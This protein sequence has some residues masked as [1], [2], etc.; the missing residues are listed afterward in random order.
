MSKIFETGYRPLENILPPYGMWTRAKAE[1]PKKILG[2]DRIFEKPL[3]VAL[4]VNHRGVEAAASDLAAFEG[5]VTEDSCDNFKLSKTAPKYNGI[6]INERKYVITNADI[7]LDG[8]GEDDFAGIGC[9]IMADHGADVVLKDSVIN[10][11]GAGRSCTMATQGARLEVHNCKLCCNGGPIPE[12]Y[13]P[14]IGPGMLEPPA[15]LKIGGTARAHLSIDNSKTY[16][17]NTTIESDGWAALSTDGAKGYVYLEANDCDLLCKNVG[18][19]FYA[20]CD[21]HVVLNHTRIKT[22]TH[23]AIMA[24][25]S[26][27][28]CVNCEIESGI[29]GFMVHTIKGL[30][31]E[32]GEVFIKGGSFHTGKECFWIKSEN[33]HLDID[34]VD[35]KSEAGLLIHSTVNDDPFATKVGRDDIV[36]GIKARLANMDLTG[37]IIHE[38]TD[39]TMAIN[40]ENTTLKGV[41]SQ[42]YVSM[43][44]SKWTATGDSEVILVGDVDVAAIDAPAGVTIAAGAGAGCAL[45]GQYLLA[46]GGILTVKQL[47]L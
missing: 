33:A 12:D 47:K 10:M 17:Y 16:F 29:Y 22:A 1:F 34:S 24:G 18:Y 40:L 25:Y 4:Q 41:I 6:R 3:T 35:L 36:F 45:L 21:C 2:M 20:D 26:Q 13:I 42:A 14:V 23:G 46:S 37:S 31:D 19:G 28:T 15:P 8:V 38:D 30:T 32:F 27:A 7:T 9:G 39:R 11:T 5:A 44:N 43:E